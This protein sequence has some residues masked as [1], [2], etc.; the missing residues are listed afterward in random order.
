MQSYCDNKVKADN[1]FAD[2]I[3][4]GQIIDVS[5]EIGTIGKDILGL[6]YVTLKTNELIHSVQ[7]VFPKN[8][9]DSLMSLQK[10][11][12]ITIRGR[13]DGAMGNVLFRNCTIIK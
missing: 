6:H 1:I 5:G 11:Q 4:K 10:R 2:N 7:C 12:S 8:K 9:S 13:C 3:F